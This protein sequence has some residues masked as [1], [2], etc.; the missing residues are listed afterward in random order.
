MVARTVKEQEGAALQGLLAGV[1]YADF[2]KRHGLPGG[3]SMLSQHLSGHRPINLTAA[4]IYATGLG[5]PIGAFSA[6]LAAEVEELRSTP[7][8]N[9]LPGPK[10][11]GPYPLISS[12]QA[13]NWSEIVD[14]FQPGDAEDW[15]VSPR[16]LGAHGFVLRVDGPSMTNPDG[17]RD[18]FPEGM[19]LHIRPETDAYPGDYV[20]V[21]RASENKATFKKLVNVDGVL[22]LFAINPAWPTPYLKLEPG[23]KIVGKLKF[24]G[25]S[26]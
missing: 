11:H 25:W 24:A 19:L 1:N 23:D 10:A 15:V 8:G 3:P 12:V 20:V 5:V 7:E 4:R 6:R 17:G 16:E 14:N 2:A 18:N 21:K 22:Y 26:F 13:G 9:T